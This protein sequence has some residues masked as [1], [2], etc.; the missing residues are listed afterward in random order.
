MR[1]DYSRL[2]AHYDA[3]RSD[4]ALDRSFWLP[5]IREAGHI[6]RHDRI[7]DLGA[8][9]GRY[10]RVLAEVGDVVALDASAAMLARARGTGS[11]GR[12]LG[13]A[14]HLPFR[15]GAFDVVVM[16]MVL[17]QLDDLRG[18]LRE[19]ARVGR[20][21]A[22]VTTDI[23]RR[24][25]GILTEA[26]PSLLAIDRAR[27]P[28]I[29]DLVATLEESGYRDIAVAVRTVR[30]ALPV[31]R[32]LDRVRHKYISTLDLLPVEEFETGLAFLEREMPRRHGGV[33]EFDSS[34][35]FVGASR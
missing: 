25:L 14:L 6:E 33:F 12:I 32:Q 15:G 29:P 11:F 23:P 21:I 4:E 3:V 34:F 26:F 2:S 9:T 16:V 35:T 1:V 31:D 7:L 13:D 17:H 5:T 27:F 20:R 28:S 19:T 8:G 22:I 18:A 24:D 10:A 30:R